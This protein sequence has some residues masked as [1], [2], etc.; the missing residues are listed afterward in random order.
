MYINYLYERDDKLK[1]E[2]LIKEFSDALQEERGVLFVGAGISKASGFKDWFELLKTLEEDIEMEIRRDDDLT[3]IAQYIVNRNM[4]NKGRLLKVIEENFAMNSERKINNYQRYISQTNV[5]TIWTTNYDVMLEKSFDGAVK[6]K[7]SDDDLLPSYSSRDEVE[8][9]KMHGCIESSTPDNIVITK[10]DYEDYALKHPLT[11]ERLKSDLINKTFLFIGYSYRDPNIQNIMNEVRQLCK[12]KT[13]PHYMILEEED[14]E[15]LKQLQS[16]WCNDLLR[17]GIN[18][19]I[20]RNREY[21][22]LEDILKKISIRSK[23]KTIYVTGSHYNDY[24][25]M[26]KEL[27]IKLA[28]IEEVTLINGQSEGIGKDVL[29]SFME[30]G[31][32]NKMDIYNRLKIYPNP[33]ANIKMDNKEEYLGELKKF[34]TPLIKNTQIVVMFDGGKGTEVEYQLALEMGSIVLP[35]IDKAE[36]KRALSMALEN[37]RIIQEIEYYDKS[38]AEKLKNK[39]KIDIEDVVECIKKIMEI[40]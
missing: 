9:I 36:R 37:E 4:G 29:Q 39:D 2:V 17:Y 27:G 3:E 35:I 15:H 32:N 12:K 25:N 20:Y 13:T 6:V 26:A 5:H 1:K 28:E 7:R 10:E 40:V 21:S 23:G 14:D 8:I 38:Y 24:N 11:I 31:I 33:Y 19:V 30:Y 18:T 22:E 34:R 16:L